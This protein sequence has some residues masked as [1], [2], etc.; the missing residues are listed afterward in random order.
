[1]ER[2]QLFLL[3]T[4]KKFLQSKPKEKEMKQYNGDRVKFARIYN[5]LTVDDLASKLNISAQAESQYEMGKITPQFDKLLGLSKVLNFPVDF[6]LKKDNISIN[7]GSSYFRSLMKTHK[8]YRTEQKTKIQLLAKLYSILSEYIEFPELNIPENIE[9]YDSPEEA[10]SFLRQFWNLG[11]KPIPNLLRLL[12]SK[13]IIVT[14]FETSTNDID[15]FSQ[16]F[17]INGK[18][19]YFIAYSNNKESAA[20]INFDL[21]HELGHIILHNWNEDTEDISRETFKEKENQANEFAAAFLLPENA[22]RNDVHYFSKELQNYIELKKKWR[23]SIAAMIHRACALGIISMNQ[24]QYLIRVMSKK[25]FRVQEPLDN[26]LE[27]PYPHLLKDAVELL[28]TNNVFSKKELLEEFSNCGFPMEPKEIEKL[29]VLDKG[30]LSNI[31]DNNDYSPLILK[32][33]SKD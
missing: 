24:Y 30:Y 20:R 16:Y 1:M 31:E 3:K 25:G 19:V 18:N 29:F 2:N 7:A 22:F 12:E 6:F 21:A 23:V 33:Y 27:I 13:G 5:G 11:E 4:L 14:S 15:A 10:A 28:I 17:N 32:M 8:K 9:S 26:I